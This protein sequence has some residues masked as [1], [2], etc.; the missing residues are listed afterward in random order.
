MMRFIRLCTN[1]KIKF[2]KLF[3]AIMPIVKSSSDHLGL[4]QAY[5]DYHAAFDDADYWGKLDA[6]VLGNIA[7]RVETL[8][9]D[10][11]LTQLYL[12][13]FAKHIKAEQTDYER[14]IKLR[15]KKPERYKTVISKLP[16][17]SKNDLL[18]GYYSYWI[19]DAPVEEIVDVIVNEAKEN[20]VFNIDMAKLS[21]DRLFEDYEKKL[22]DENNDEEQV[23]G[24]VKFDV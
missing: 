21:A 6:N 15:E 16:E 1:K 22:A 8:D 2:I 12:K 9:D 4:E 24:G 7:V 20:E 5:Y 18:F 11:K 10:D 14:L 13:N 23:T 3:A 19:N 17:E